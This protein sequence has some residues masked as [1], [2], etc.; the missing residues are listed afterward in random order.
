MS[1]ITPKDCTVLE[2]QMMVTK[3]YNKALETAAIWSKVNSST[4]YYW[5]YIASGLHL[6]ATNEAAHQASI[7]FYNNSTSGIIDGL[8]EKIAFDV[9][10]WHQTEDM[11]FSEQIITDKETDSLVI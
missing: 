7:A 9:M 2:F 5:Q 4:E 8:F 3:H 6:I 10:E 1:T 11:A